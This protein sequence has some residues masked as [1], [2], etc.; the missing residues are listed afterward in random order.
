LAVSVKIYLKRR[1]GGAGGVY[2]VLF[3]VGLKYCIIKKL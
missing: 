2:G 3:L 1:G